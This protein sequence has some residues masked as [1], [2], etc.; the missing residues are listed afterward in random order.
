MSSFRHLPRSAALHFSRIH[1]TRPSVSSAPKISGYSSRFGGKNGFASVTDS[2]TPENKGND[3][4]KAD[5]AMIIA[6]EYD[7][8]TTESN[9]ILDTLLDT[10][11]EVRAFLRKRYVIV[12]QTSCLSLFSRVMC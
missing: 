8:K 1:S 12:V 11:V 2:P 3:L 6:A 4:T 10:V 9:R 5:L 7:M